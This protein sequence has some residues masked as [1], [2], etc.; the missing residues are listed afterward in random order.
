LPHDGREDFFVYD[1]NNRVIKDKY[2]RNYSEIE[3]YIQ[4][5]IRNNLES[6]YVPLQVLDTEDPTFDVVWSFP[7]QYT[8]LDHF[9]T[10]NGEDE[11]SESLIPNLVTDGSWR[12]Q[13]IGVTAKTTRKFRIKDTWNL[14]YTN[15]TISADVTYRGKVYHISKSMTFGESGSDGSEFTVSIHQGSPSTLGLT[16]S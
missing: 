8:M 15:N 7:E 13:A 5:W 14:Q 11:H 9:A 16:P 10:I 2:N 3:Y 6:T 12:D 1:E 4:V